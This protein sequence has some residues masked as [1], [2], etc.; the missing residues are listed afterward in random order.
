MKNK[1]IQIKT[2]F[3][4]IKKL[5]YE[6][7]GQNNKLTVNISN[8]KYELKQI[9]FKIYNKSYDSTRK[10]L[11]INNKYYCCIPEAPKTEIKKLLKFIWTL[12]CCNISLDEIKQYVTYLTQKKTHKQKQ[13]YFK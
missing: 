5:K 6:N 8:A 9:R 1:T 7:I 2:S 4:F 11:Y 3:Y 10:Q 12:Y 13:Y